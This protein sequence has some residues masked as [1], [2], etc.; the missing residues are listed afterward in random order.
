MGECTDQRFIRILPAYSD[1]IGR[2]GR[3]RGEAGLISPAIWPPGEQRIER[4]CAL[5]D[6]PKPLG[7]HAIGAIPGG[8]NDQRQR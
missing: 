6:G 1:S 2:P 5:V 7:G 8:V 4:P 3:Q